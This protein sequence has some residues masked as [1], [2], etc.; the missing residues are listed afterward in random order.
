MA[1]QQPP[2]AVVPTQNAPPSTP[3]RSGCGRGCGFGCGGCL[4]AVVLVVLL[5]VGGSYWF[6]VVQA[7]AAVDAPATLVVIN[8]PVTVDGHAAIP[9]QALI[10]GNTAVTGAGGHASIQFPDGSFIR[11]APGTSVTVT[12]VQLQK[13]GNLQKATV[14]QNVGRTFESVEH[15][16]TGATFQVG[17][18]SVTAS[19]R[20][21]KFETLVRT[22]YSSRIW[23]FEGVVRVSGKTTVDLHAGQEIDA[24]AN[25]NLSAP[26]SNQFDLTDSFPLAAACAKASND[27]ASDRRD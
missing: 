4:L 16:A 27:P 10:A 24:D 13:N 18:H 15:L 5:A 3:R 19:V 25:G 1:I 9:G 22:D 17:S 6:F 11:M 7:S 12:A 21:T 20:G 2:A 8:P 23:V 26:R 14:L